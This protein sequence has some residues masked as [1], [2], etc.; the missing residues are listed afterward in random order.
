M[1]LG[2]LCLVDS[3]AHDGI[4]LLSDGAYPAGNH[5]PGVYPDVD[6]KGNLRPKNSDR[7]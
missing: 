4:V 1:T 7:K 5:G 6:V 2:G 3:I